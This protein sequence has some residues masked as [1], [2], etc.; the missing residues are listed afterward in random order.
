MASPSLSLRHDSAAAA[1]SLGI[2][3]TLDI[4]IVIGVKDLCEDGTV[5]IVS[6]ER[7][8]VGRSAL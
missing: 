3:F 4:R 6:K 7:E 1:A 2:L 8:C 5:G